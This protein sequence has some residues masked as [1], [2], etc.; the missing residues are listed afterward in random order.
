MTDEHNYT[1]RV[2]VQELKGQLQRSQS[3]LF[4]S[5]SISSILWSKQFLFLS[6]FR[7]N[8]FS[9][10]LLDLLLH[11]DEYLMQSGFLSGV[12]CVTLRVS[13]SCNKL[14]TCIKTNQR[15]SF[16]QSRLHFTYRCMRSESNEAA[17]F[18]Q[19]ISKNQF[20]YDFLC[21]CEKDGA[22]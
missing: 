1:F 18:N 17:L 3:K 16:F 19:T 13:L 10:V 6:T 9:L 14:H 12:F 7:F 11:E 21:F 15:R 8:F 5:E 22:Q 2:R 4:L 20:C